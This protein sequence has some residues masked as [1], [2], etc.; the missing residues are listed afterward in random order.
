MNRAASG[1]QKEL[2]SYV[3]IAC[4]LA[5]LAFLSSNII[6]LKI[7]SNTADDVQLA[8][9]MQLVEHEIENQYFMHARDQSQ[10]SNWDD[11]L[12]ALEEDVDLEFVKSEI[13]DWLFSDFDIQMSIVVDPKNMPRVA[14]YE[15]TILDPSKAQNAIDQ[16]IDLVNKTREKFVDYLSAQTVPIE[17][18]SGIHDP[19]RSASPIYAAG[20]RHF[21]GQI[22][23]VVAQVLV[24]HDDYPMPSGTPRV[25]L[26]FK[27]V[28]QANL[29]KINQ[30]LELENF[31]LRIG[32]MP[33]NEE[34]QV[35]KLSEVPREGAIY[36]S[37]HHT[38]ASAYIWKMAYPTFG[39]ALLISL[40]ALVFVGRKFATTV[41]Q[42]QR[43]EEQN[44]FLALHDSLTGLP[45]R[46]FFDRE[47][48]TII[49]EQKQDRCAILCM[50]LDHFKA[51]NDSFGH[52]AGDVVLKT[53]SDRL[54]TIVEESGFASR[55]GGDE[56]IILVKNHLD[57]DSVM[58]LSDQLIEE[59]CKPI[60]IPGAS[61]QVGAS[62]GVAWWPDDAL[63]VKSI[64]R[65]AD[66][67]L[68]YSKEKG[69]G[70]VSCADQL[71]NTGDQLKANS[72]QTVIDQMRDATSRTG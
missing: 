22:S 1:K 44:R 53:I 8:K 55:V 24:P 34:K 3:W 32:G 27:P 35:L 67:A 51:V 72:D 13:A 50:D 36:A 21:N 33:S 10:I 68:Y 56:F 62:I 54:S 66:E 4:I 14:V 30:K 48:E 5:T 71:H 47:L 45:N 15:E 58:Y 23:T 59:A 69:R 64:I 28:T 20:F 61:V 31:E 17:N 60:E 65:S 63:T 70:T 57:K 12:K 38:K 11:A 25:L 40:L 42:L 52:H 37:W 18:F 6:M 9:Q 29:S 16:N 26:T 41:E 39:L 7:A 46:L 49:A 19:I 43:S 2:K